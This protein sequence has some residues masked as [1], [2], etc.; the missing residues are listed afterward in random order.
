MGEKK[1]QDVN[2]K[3][4][5]LDK[6][7]RYAPNALINFFAI[8][9]IGLMTVVTFDLDWSYIYSPRFIVTSIVLMFIFMLVHWSFYDGKLKALRTNKENREYIKEQEESIKKVTQTKEWIDHRQEFI[10]ERNQ[11][12]KIKAHITNTQNKLTKLKEKAK[13]VDKNI[14]MAQVTKF[15]K[16]YLEDKEIEKLEKQYEEARVN[17]AYCQRKAELEYQ[18]TEEWIGNNI[19]KINIDYNEIDSQFV[20]TGSV[21]KGIKKDKVKA[22]GKYLKDNGLNRV[23]F[24]VLSIAVSSIAAEPLAEGGGAEQWVLFAFRLMLVVF[25]L[26]TGLNYGNQFYEEYDLHNINSRV[27][28]K[29]EFTT[30]AYDKGYFVKKV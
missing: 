10:L 4:G 24:L 27:S 23:I 11:K 15:Q 19:H 5:Y 21:I 18:L 9:I 14:D 8:L 16:E 26:T 6:I 22:K 29:N 30:W 1:E 12:E 7:I 17:N 28:I 20:E 25:N 13:Q 2:V 3:R